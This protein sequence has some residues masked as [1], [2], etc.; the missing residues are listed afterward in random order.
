MLT[1]ALLNFIGS[2]CAHEIW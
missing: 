2:S 1:A